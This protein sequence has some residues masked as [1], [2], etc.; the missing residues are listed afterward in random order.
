MTRQVN[1][2]TCRTAFVG[3]GGRGAGGMSWHAGMSRGEAVTNAG[4]RM[5]PLQ[6]ETGRPGLANSPTC[7][8]LSTPTHTLTHTHTQTGAEN[9]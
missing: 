4:A 1:Y 5:H 7:L 9:L 3:A 6:V 2:G 8:R